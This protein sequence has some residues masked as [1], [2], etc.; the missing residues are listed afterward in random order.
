MV[1][2]LTW[3]IWF[4]EQNILQRTLQLIE[5]IKQLNPDIIALQEV[6]EPIS[7]IL[8]RKLNYNFAGFPLEQTYDTLLLSKYE[9]QDYNRILL[10]DS[11]MGR[12]LLLTNFTT[13]PFQVGTFHLESV[14]DKTSY[15]KINQLNYCEEI[16]SENAILMGD[17]NFTTQYP[18]TN[19]KD[20]FQ[21]ISE[22]EYYKFT[23]DGKTN[24]NIKSKRQSR[25]DRIYTKKDYKIQ[26]FYLTGTELQQSDHYGVFTKLKI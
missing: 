10:P 14:F 13:L 17:T 5:E 24:K 8:K 3:N 4:D 25:L 21:T 23:Y 1:S 11:K 19:L 15:K 18:K 7:H 2:L 9:I 12:N 16:T 20:V 6:T 26:E 22:P